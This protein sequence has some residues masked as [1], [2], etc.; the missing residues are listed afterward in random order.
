MKRFIT[1][2]ACLV[3]AALL[4][5]AP[6]SL[7]QSTA[8]VTLTGAG[9]NIVF[10]GVYVGPYTGTING[11]APTSIICDDYSDETYIGESWT[12]TIYGFSSLSSSTGTGFT[13]VHWGGTSTTSQLVLYEEAAWLTLQMLNLPK[14]SSMWG[15]YSFAIWDLFVPGAD[16]GLS[17]AGQSEVSSLIAQAQQ[18]YASDSYSNFSIYTPGPNADPT[19]GGGP[20]PTAPPQEFLVEMAPPSGHTVAAAESPTL[21]LLVTDLLGLLALIIV[22]RRHIIRIPA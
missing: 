6:F 21:I 9:G 3:G 19:C 22:F 10:D 20:C 12:A 2:C 17:S 5:S 11:G 13:G 8:Q 15:Y 1:K 16:S 18:N 14:S 7:A 4:S